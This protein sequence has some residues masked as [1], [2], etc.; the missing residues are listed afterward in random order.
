MEKEL[1]D[2]IGRLRAKA[3]AKRDAAKAAADAEYAADMESIGRLK[4]LDGDGAEVA[5]PRVHHEPTNG[6]ASRHVRR[7]RATA[8]TTRTERKVSRKDGPTL[9]VRKV[10]QQTSGQFTVDDLVKA[11]SQMNGVAVTDRNPIYTA[12]N[13]LCRSGEVEKLPRSEGENFSYFRIIKLK[14]FV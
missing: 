10:L 1:S 6:T 5:A 8:E 12:L 7:T 14:A 13:K 9:D 3:A 4:S 11:I 2:I